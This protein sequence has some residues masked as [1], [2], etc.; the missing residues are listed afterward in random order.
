[1]PKLPFTPKHVRTLKRIKICCRQIKPIKDISFI[2]SSRSVD[3]SALTLLVSFCARSNFSCRRSKS[4]WAFSRA[5]WVFSCCSW[6][7]PA[8]AWNGRRRKKSKKTR[9]DCRGRAYVVVFVGG[10]RRGERLTGI[11]L[12]SRGERNKE[13]AKREFLERFSFFSLRN[14]DAERLL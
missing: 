6:Y 3:P 4:D 1:M 13:R 12:H 7:L 2:R 14:G 9:K 8:E 5:C 11:S 10:S